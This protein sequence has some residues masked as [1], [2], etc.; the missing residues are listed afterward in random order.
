MTKVSQRRMVK[1]N[2]AKQ[3]S[4]HHQLLWSSFEFDCL[5]LLST[6][7]GSPTA[8]TV[9]MCVLMMPLLRT[10]YGLGVSL[11]GLVLLLKSQSHSATSKSCNDTERVRDFNYD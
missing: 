4:M 8:A 1:A 6:E 3:L 11:D 2:T 9:R 7:T 5:K 10:L